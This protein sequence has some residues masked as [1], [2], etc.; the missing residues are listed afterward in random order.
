[1]RLRLQ[2]QLVIVMIA[3]LSVLTIVSLLVLRHSVQTEV[4]RQTLDAV[5]SSVHAFDRLQE[6]QFASLLRTASMMAE[7]P[8]LKA[9]LAT[10]HPTTIQDASAE[11]W[12][13]SG[14][15]LL[16][17]GDT[18][19]V[20]MAVHA[21]VAN[22]GTES[23]NRI[24]AVRSAEEPESWWYDESGLYRIVS[25][26]VTAGSGKDQQ[27]L[28]TIVLGLRI[29]DAVAQ[30]IGRLT[31][32]EVVLGVGDSIL[33]TTLSSS[34]RAGLKDVLRNQSG[35][36][37]SVPREIRIGNRRFETASIVLQTGSKATVR[38]YMLIP[39]EETYAFLSRLNIT[40]LV[41]ALMVALLGAALLRVISS[42][43][44]R[45]L[46]KL[47]AAVKALASGD[48]N[49]RVEL[50]GSVEVKELGS[51]FVSMRRDL[52]ESQQ[53][54]IEAE[55]LAALG[56][57]AGSISHDLRHHLAA[58]VANAEF[59]H[60]SKGPDSDR[61]DLYRE[62]QRASDQMT[63]LIDSLVEISR[64]RST[65]SLAEDELQQIV[66]RARDSL[67]ANP[68]FRQQQID[69]TSSCDT[70]G[71][72]DA[73]KLQRAFFNLLLNAY[74][75]TS[76]KS[77]MVSVDIKSVGDT[78]EC[79]ITDNGHGI[80]DAVKVSMFEPFVSAGKNNGTGLGLT[81]ATKIIRDHSGEVVL[82]STSS[83]GT[84]FLVRLPRR[85]APERTAPAS[86]VM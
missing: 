15:D 13:L 41:L 59:L 77:G 83:E 64:E 26:Q 47:V 67:K 24:L 86:A 8:T 84:T 70:R 78:L 14:T 69:I 36:R 61:D 43:I 62:I 42:A 4:R 40:I 73:Q 25:Q 55:R 19:G 60:D 50:K 32:T 75:A 33:A 2:S 22:L 51:A 18:A 44:T 39:L 27:A 20:P 76:A 46:E 52:V 28:G 56:R 7:L 37:D 10:K 9:V 48:P 82:E 63:V 3:V 80:P 29:N 30:E 45:P 31:G 12:K 21:S 65:L 16:I 49:Y 11:F 1:M 72:F 74:E 81:I 57:A 79:R 53:R 34:D 54:Q 66:V 38:C 17:L 85:S 58:L 6:Q 5:A 35:E 23:A 68:D 71:M